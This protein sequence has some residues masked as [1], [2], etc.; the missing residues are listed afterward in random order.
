MNQEALFLSQVL[1]A[2]AVSV[3]VIRYLRGILRAMLLEICDR[4]PQRAEF[5]VRM[6]DM[7]MLIAPVILVAMFWNEDTTISNMLRRTLLLALSGQFISLAVVAR[8]LW[9]L[10]QQQWLPRP[11]GAGPGNAA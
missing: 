11:V 10:L 3:G 7:M 2:V 4:Q 6:L 1:L 8:T 5:W 9:N